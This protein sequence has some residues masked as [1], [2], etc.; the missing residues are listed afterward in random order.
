MTSPS[1]IRTEN[2]RQLADFRYRLRVFLAFSEQAAEAAGITA[3][4]YQLLQSVGLAETDGLT[5]TVIAQR[6]LLRHNSA[7]ELVDRAERADLV[8]R[9]QDAGD[10][11]RAVVVLTARGR[12]I[13]AR[14]L[15]EHLGYLRQGGP[16]ML[17][18]L[19]RVLATAAEGDR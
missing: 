14:L 1:L 2:F 19:E 13:L 18:A 8:R 6:M 12:A 15:E 4:H 3:Q 11:R 16:P 17:Q 5:I 10:H 9:T 7:V